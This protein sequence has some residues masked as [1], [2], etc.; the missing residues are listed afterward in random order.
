MSIEALIFAIGCGIGVISGTLGIG[1]GIVLAPL[2]LY[3]PPLLGF[4]PMDMKAIS[5]LTMVQSVAT[6]LTGMLLHRKSRHVHGRLAAVMG[7]TLAA[8][9]F[10]GALASGR[11]S[12]E[13][14]LAVLAVVAFAAGV[15][16]ILP[17]PGADREVPSSDVPINAPLAAGV[18]AAIGSVGGLIGQS[19]AF[20]LNPALIVIL[21]V[22]TRVTIGTSLAIVSCAG[23]AGTLGKALAGQIV[24]VPALTLCAGAALGTVAGSRL[25]GKIRVRTLRLA[26]AVLILA[27]AV[28]MAADVLTR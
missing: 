21:R 7:A 26:L 8:A 13:A 16:L 19:G 15:I 5:G 17:N 6:G 10:A 23:V 27:S 28:R 18:A 22:P 12:S 20:L 9:A 3:L 24:L 14:L 11:V 4:V 25:S 1:G 2:L